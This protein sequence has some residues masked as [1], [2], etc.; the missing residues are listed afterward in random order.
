V[1]LADVEAGVGE[2]LAGRRDRGLRHA[3]P[4][5]PGEPGGKDAGDT[6]SI[7]QLP[8][9]VLGRHHHTSRPVSGVGLCAVAHDTIGGHRRQLGQRFGVRVVDALVVLDDERVV[10]APFDGHRHHPGALKGPVVGQRRPVLLVADE[11]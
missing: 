4:L 10:P 1:D 6:F 3:A 2:C 5:H 7:G 8:G 9:A 11:G